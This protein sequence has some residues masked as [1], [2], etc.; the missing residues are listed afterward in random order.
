MNILVAGS[1]GLIGTPFV[2]QLERDGHTVTRLVR[3]AHSASESEVTWDPYQRTVDDASLSRRGPFDALVNFAGAG[4]GDRRWSKERRELIVVSRTATTSFMVEASLPHLAASPRLLNASAIGF[5]GDRGDEELTET[6]PRG[7]GF[8]AD[9]C[10]QWESAAAAGRS[11]GLTVTT[12]RTGIVLDR[13]GGALAKQLPLFR[14]GLG[15][16]FGSGHQWMSPISLRDTVRALSFLLDA[17]VDGPVNLTCPTPLTGR[18]FAHS[19]GRQIHRPAI[20]PAPSVALRVALGGTMADE[21]LL[22]SQRVLPSQLLAAG[23]E[24]D[25]PD[26]GTILRQLWTV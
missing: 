1:S 14:V 13:R 8:L 22:S 19:L 3:R 15:G 2:E 9:V 21:L 10:E 17:D 20:V 7:Q 23:F 26:V 12:L 25:G 11:A 4:I 24:F 18:D 6:S 16:P 5:Y